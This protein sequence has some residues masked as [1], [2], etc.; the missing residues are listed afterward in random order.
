MKKRKTMFFLMII[1]LSLFLKLD[2]ANAVMY[3]GGA[4]NIGTG[5]SD[6]TCNFPTNKS[7]CPWDNAHKTVKITV[8]FIYNG[9][10]VANKG[11]VYLTTNKAYTEGAY[12]IPNFKLM[13]GNIVSHDDTWTEIF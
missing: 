3:N 6:G 8:W 9:E 2:V 10:F 7:L 5:S 11:S 12:A 13:P 4:S 1:F